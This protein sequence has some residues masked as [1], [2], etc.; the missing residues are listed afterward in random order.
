[1]SLVT[2]SFPRRQDLFTLRQNTLLLL[3]GLYQ[4]RNIQL[5]VLL[6]FIA[7]SAMQGIMPV[8]TYEYSHAPSA[9]HCDS[10]SCSLMGKGKCMCAINGHHDN[11]KGSS[12]HRICGCTHHSEVPTIFNNQVQVKATLVTTLN[13]VIHVQD[14]RY[15]FLEEETTG[16]YA[17]EVFHPPRILAWLFSLIVYYSTNLQARWM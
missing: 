13:L 5:L 15:A 8:M 16:L 3:N 10:T 12:E 14:K 6:L 2:W 17:R 1:M 4:L 7:T 9:K 11:K